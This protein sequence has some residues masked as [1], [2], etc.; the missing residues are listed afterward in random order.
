MQ[1]SVHEVNKTI[2]IDVECNLGELI[3]VLEKRFPKGEWKDYKLILPVRQSLIDFSKQPIFDQNPVP[4]DPSIG[5]KPWTGPNIVYC[6][7]D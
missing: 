4:F 1:Y 5:D 3:S 7:K 2:Q 6:K